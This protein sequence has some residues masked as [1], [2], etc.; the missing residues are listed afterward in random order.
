MRH[1]T[2]RQTREHADL[3]AKLSD[4]EYL[5]NTRSEHLMLTEMHRFLARERHTPVG[6]ARKKLWAQSRS[7]LARPNASTVVCRSRYG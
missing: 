1:V 2:P 4:L 7:R 6:P 5:G 3:T